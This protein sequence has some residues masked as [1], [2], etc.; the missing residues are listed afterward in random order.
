M[1]EELYAASAYLSKNPLLTSSIKAQDFGKLAIFTILLLGLVFS[2][3]NSNIIM[4]LL[5]VR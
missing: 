2:I 1:G 5:T 3:F 4:N